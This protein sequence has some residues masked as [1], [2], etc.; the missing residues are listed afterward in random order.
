MTQEESQAAETE[1]DAPQPRWQLFRNRA[2]PL[3]PE[4]GAAGAPLVAVITVMSFLAVLAMASLLMVNRAASEWTSELRSEITVQI[5]G[6][7]ETEIAAG[8]SAALRVLEETEGVIEAEERGREETAALLEPWLGQGNASAFLNIPAIIEVKA[9]PTLH[10]NLELLRNRLEA[11]A[12]G[13][14]LDDHSRWH[15]RL[16]NAARSGQ[17]MAF[18]VFLLVMGAACAISIFAARAG[19]AANHEIV[20]VLHLVGATDDFIATEV[21]RRFFILG[22]RGAVLGLAAALLALGLTGMVMRS[23]LAADSFLPEFS[24]GGFMILWLLAA[25]VATCLVTALTAR[26]TVLKTLSR[27]Y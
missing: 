12:P 9:T 22:L 16:S 21:Q 11:A 19:L 8:V 23:G 17:A 2:A 1:G 4:A 20:S 6:A 27:Q 3:L 14:S 24:V 25:P 10:D 26:L 5:K 18:G 13:A 7:N 15:D